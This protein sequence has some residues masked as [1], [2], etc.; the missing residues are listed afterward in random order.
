MITA[1]ELKHRIIIQRQHIEIDTQ[2]GDRQVS[3]QHIAKIWA[4]ISPVSVREFVQNQQQQHQVNTRIT[5]R[6][7]KDIDTDCRLVHDGKIYNIIGI[8]ADAYTGKE[9]LT[10]ACEHGVIDV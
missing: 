8:L 9:Y 7:R 6:Y 5:I 2:T 10:L 1:G 3:W 4:K